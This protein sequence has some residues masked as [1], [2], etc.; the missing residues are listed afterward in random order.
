MSDPD[1]N[2]PRDLRGP[3]SQALRAELHRRERRRRRTEVPTI[4]ALLIVGSLIAVAARDDPGFML[5]GVWIAG[6]GLVFLA[7]RCA[8]S[9]RRW[10]PWGAAPLIA[11][12]G[13]TP[14][15]VIPADVRA[16]RIAAAIP[17]WTAATLAASATALSAAADPVGVVTAA[18]AI[19]FGV[20][21]VRA[22]L[23]ARRPGV[24]MTPQQLVV[25]DA[26]GSLTVAWAEVVDVVAPSAASGPVVLRVA[27]SRDRGPA[28][29][30][31]A[32]T[33]IKGI[34]TDRLPET[35]EAI[36]RVLTHYRS[37]AAAAELGTEQ[38][39]GTVQRLLGGEGA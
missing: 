10:I 39:L 14:A 27:V 20:F 34:P 28:A 19:G 17:G 32:L 37:A 38:S 16:D 15:T 36:A 6:L 33:T 26:R 35:G 31:E 13:G 2:G 5:L 9:S 23:R 25:R 12:T 24:W 8:R 7:A 1:R 4:S 21:T 18:G 11:E 29:S 3:S 30:G 22:V